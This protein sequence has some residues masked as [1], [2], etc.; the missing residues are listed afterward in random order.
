MYPSEKAIARPEVKAFMD[1][2][3]ANQADIAKAAKIVPLTAEQASRPRTTLD[4]GREQAALARARGW[5]V[6]PASGGARG[7]RTSLVRTPSRRS[8]FEGAIKVALFAAA[9]VSVVTTLRSSSRC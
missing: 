9:R 7:P 6:T 3:V 4:E 2:V 5:L 8:R 1:F